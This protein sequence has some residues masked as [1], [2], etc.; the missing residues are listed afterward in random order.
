MI[1]AVDIEAEK[2]GRFP[3]S[4]V[5]LGQ[6]AASLIFACRHRPTTDIPH[7]VFLGGCISTPEQPCEESKRNDCRTDSRPKP[8]MD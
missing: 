2:D 7:R 3:G 1:A 5:R 8:S 4:F 6:E